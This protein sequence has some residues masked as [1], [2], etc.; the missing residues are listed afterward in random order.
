MQDRIKAGA[1]LVDQDALIDAILTTETLTEAANVAGCARRT[2]Y[3]YLADE[4]FMQRLE[5][6]RD[7]R[8]KR[9]ED[10]LD[11]AAVKAVNG[12]VGII[13]EDGFMVTAGDR[14]KAAE[15]LLKMIR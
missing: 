8:R 7:Q 4:S 1:A 13:E 15:L 9:I 14:L 10:V 11:V 3:N 2:V 5:W 6:A 12:L